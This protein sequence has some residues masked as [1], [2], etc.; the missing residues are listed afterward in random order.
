MD[1]SEHQD[2]ER[3]RARRF[4]NKTGLAFPVIERVV[5][6]EYRE[7][8]ARLRLDPSWSVL[9]VGTGTGALAQTL[10]ERGHR[11]VG[12]DF[13]EKLL[14]RA[15]RRVPGVDFEHADIL[16]PGTMQGRRFDLVTMAY[17]LHG[18]SPALRRQVLVRARELATRHV[19]IVDYA[20]RGTWLTRLVEWVEGPHYFEFIRQPFAPALWDAGLGVTLR[21]RTRSGGGFWLCFDR[22]VAARSARS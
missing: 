7:L 9:D 5:V 22:S 2:D 6:P 11:V 17:V 21:G 8:T 16:A 18:M 19:L 1:L 4:F 15:R 3:R 20:R 13:S 10:A 12:V 14:A